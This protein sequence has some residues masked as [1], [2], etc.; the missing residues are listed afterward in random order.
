MTRIVTDS[1]CDLPRELIERHGITVVPMLVEIDGAEFHE[2]VDITPREFYAK[3]AR[4][5]QLPKTS[6]PSPALFEEKF[7]DLG[8]DGPVLCITVSSKLSGTY[9]SACLAAKL[10][11]ADVTVFDTLTASL[12]HGMQIL[13]ACELIDAGRSV[14]EIVEALTT[15]SGEMNTLVL[16]NTLVNIVK[17]GRLSRFQG[18]VSKVLDIRVLLHDEA[19]EVVLLEKVHGHRRLMEKAVEKLH[20]MHPDLSDRDVGITHF[21]NLADAEAISASIAACC[22]P[23]GFIINE[24]GTS[25]ATYAGEGGMIVSF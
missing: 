13:K 15:Y 8:A 18:S 3:M 2:G 5:T 9:Q 11:G 16:L 14:P 21:N 12:G 22:H 6:Q 23:R 17:G 1:S 24:M 19:G 10:S 20:E 25:M 7:R 4:S